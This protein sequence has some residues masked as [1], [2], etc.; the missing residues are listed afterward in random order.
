MDLQRPSVTED[1]L[2]V[3]FSSDRPVVNQFL[4]F[5]EELLKE[6]VENVRKGN[7]NQGTEK[8]VD[9][10]SP[11]NKKIKEH[12]EILRG[13][14][15]T[16]EKVE[17]DAEERDSHILSGFIPATV[18]HLPPLHTNPGSDAGMAGQNDIFLESNIF[19]CMQGVSNTRYVCSS[20]GLH[21]FFE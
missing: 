4:R 9:L 19:R 13:K 6:E 15:T 8:D 14:E 1:V 18:R 17:W 20:V 5:V 12:V 3:V 11:P 10:A 2:G 21:S 16:Y 7:M